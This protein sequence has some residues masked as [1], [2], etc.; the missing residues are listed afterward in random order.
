MANDGRNARKE[1]RTDGVRE[2]A[3]PEGMQAGTPLS[4]RIGEDRT[5]L[6]RINRVNTA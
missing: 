6:A 1:G 3:F 5:V 4:T 2:E